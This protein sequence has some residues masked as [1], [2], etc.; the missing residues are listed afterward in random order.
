MDF[1]YF[2]FSPL[3]LALSSHT[4]K[5]SMAPL[6]LH[7]HETV[8]H[9]DKALLTKLLFSRLNKASSLSL[10]IFERWTKPSLIL[11]VLHE[12]CFCSSMSLRLENAELNTD[13]QICLSTAEWKDKDHLVTVEMLLLM[14]P[15]RL[16]SFA[17]TRAHGW[18]VVNPQKPFWCLLPA[19]QPLMPCT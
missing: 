5:K 12:A 16:L 3:L 2:S 8:T 14:Q 6:L 13:F 9:I 4:P 19:S 17:T 11:M 15:S 1:L 7:P 10:S 18:L